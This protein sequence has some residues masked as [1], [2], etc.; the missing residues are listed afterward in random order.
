MFH[1]VYN[2]IFSWNVKING[3]GDF[4]ASPKTIQ[5]L[6]SLGLPI[7]PPIVMSWRRTEFN[8]FRDF[9]TLAQAEKWLEISKSNKDFIDGSIKSVSK[10]IVGSYSVQYN[11]LSD[12]DKI[13]AWQHCPVVN[14]PPL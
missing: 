6:N 5:T 4:L 2:T 11:S 12:E 14:R 13:D 10:K 1:R 7:T 8:I 9:D 3:Q